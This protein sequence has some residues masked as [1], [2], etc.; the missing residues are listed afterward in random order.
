MSISREELARIAELARL[1]L[2]P[3]REDEMSR[4]LSEVLEFA[5]SLRRL[6]LDGLDPSV[7]ASPE[8]ALRDDVPNGRRLDPETATAAAPEHED[9]FFLVPPIVEDLSP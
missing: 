2:P 5:E 3:E 1:D 9:G 7:F 6:D 4:Q 8:G